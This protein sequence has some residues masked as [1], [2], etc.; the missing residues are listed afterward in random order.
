MGSSSNETLPP[1]TSAD[2]FED[3]KSSEQ[4]R[5]LPTVIFLSLIIGTGLVGNIFVLYVF[6]TKTVRDHV[7]YSA[8]H[9]S[10]LVDVQRVE[11]YQRARHVH[12]F[13]NFG[14]YRCGPIP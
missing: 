12:D 11:V 2:R 13:F 1:M 7:A 4:Q 8:V 3:I 9:D 10:E 5:L 14:I 6:G